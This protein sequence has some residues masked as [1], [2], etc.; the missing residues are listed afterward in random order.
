MVWLHLVIKLIPLKPR[1]KQPRRNKDALFRS[2]TLS[3]ECVFTD[4]ALSHKIKQQ[5]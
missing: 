4:V 3:P 5:K 2:K 1:E